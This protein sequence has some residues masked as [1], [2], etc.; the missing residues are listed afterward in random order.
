MRSVVKFT[1]DQHLAEAAEVAKSLAS[2]ELAQPGE[3]RLGLPVPTA[4]LL[5]STS[6]P[7]L[8]SR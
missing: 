6:V 7:E 2:M 8:M 5:P 4:M 1:G 3:E